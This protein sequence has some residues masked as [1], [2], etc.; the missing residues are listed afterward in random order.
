MHFQLSLVISQPSFPTRLAYGLNYRPEIGGATP[1]TWIIFQVNGESFLPNLWSG[2]NKYMSKIAQVSR[3]HLVSRTALL[4]FGVF[5]ASTATI[6]VKASRELPLLMTA[7]RLLIAALVLTPFF[8]RE[9]KAA[10]GDF[11]W[12][13]FGWACLPAVVLAINMSI[14]VVGARMTQAAD[15]GLIVSL[16]PLAMPFFLWW[17]MR[18][19]INRQEVFGTLV[20]LAGILVLFGGNLHASHT[21]FIGDMIVVASMLALTGYL[22]LGRKNAARLSLWLYIV[23]LYWVA[24]LICLA[25]ALFFVNPI[26][27]YA[28]PDLLAILGLGVISTALGQT[29][30][31]YSFQHFRGQTVSLTLM[32]LPLFTGAMGYLFFGEI[33]HPSFYLAAL[34]ISA[35]IFVALR[36]NQA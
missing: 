7:G 12:R 3:A 19:K 17:L 5:C 26:K 27:A 10:P 11:G 35:G 4:L 2:R 20:M 25:A 9:L 16:T 30:L 23:P 6:F 29:L 28:M 1:G 31:N 8:L 13:Q 21:N 15:A 33:P 32:L 18:E 36:S 24:G 22:A 14:F 34:L